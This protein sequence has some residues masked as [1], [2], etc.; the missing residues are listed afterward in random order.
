MQF[1][2]FTVLDKHRKMEAI[3]EVGAVIMGPLTRGAT[4]A[5]KSAQQKAKKSKRPFLE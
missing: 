1:F 3:E 4:F 5:A 2:I